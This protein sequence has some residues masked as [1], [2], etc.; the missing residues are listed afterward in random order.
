MTPS[1][2]TP[3]RTASLRIANREIAALQSGTNEMVPNDTDFHIHRLACRP[4][5]PSAINHLR[6]SSQHASGS[7]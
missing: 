4:L 3:E 2:S 1:G 6:D 5:G 7:Q